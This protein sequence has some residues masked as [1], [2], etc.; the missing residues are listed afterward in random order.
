LLDAEGTF[1]TFR[2][3]FGVDDDGPWN[4]PFFAFLVVTG[5]VTVVVDTGVGPPGGADPFLP[6][7]QGR[8]PDEL[9]AAG[10]APPDVDLVVLTHLHVDHVGWTMAGGRTFFPN[11]RYV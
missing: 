4:L 7:R 2:E 11:A 1:A 6:E 8:L 5:G 3:A 9:A 10:V